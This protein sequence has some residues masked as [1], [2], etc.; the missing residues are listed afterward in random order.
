M[1]YS[2]S[3]QRRHRTAKS[4]C[5]ICLAVG[6]AQIEAPDTS[7]VG[8]GGQSQINVGG[9]SGSGRIALS[10]STGKAGAGG[11]RTGGTAGKSSSGGSKASGGSTSGGTGAAGKASGA[12]AGKAA[13][14]GTRG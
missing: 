4:A 13:S 11:R 2:S 1:D 3:G 7:G 12:T 10:G 8:T 14:G 6:C 9:D 5:L